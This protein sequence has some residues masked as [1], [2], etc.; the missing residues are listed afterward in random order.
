[1]TIYSQYRTI[2]IAVVWMGVALSVGA[3]AD[4]ATNCVRKDVRFDGLVRLEYARVSGAPDTK[5]YL[6]KSFPASCSLTNPESCESP[7]YLIGGDS[8]ALGKICGSWAFVQYIGRE[9]VTIGWVVAKKLA[10]APTASRGAGGKRYRFVLT[11]GQGVPVC[12]AYLQRLNQTEFHTP[13]Y[14]DR[15]ESDVVP[16]FAVLDRRYLDRAEYVATQTDI[17]D[18]VL[19]RPPHYDYVRHRNPDGSETLV[20]PHL[21]P[22]VADFSPA[23]WR[24]APPVD[25]ENSGHPDDL[26]IW[27]PDARN[28]PSMCGERNTRNNERIPGDHA[29]II[30]FPGRDQIDTDRTLALFGFSNLKK[31]VGG[32]SEFGQAY[33]VFKFLGTTYYDTFFLTPNGDFDGKRGGD[34]KLSDT[35][36]VFLYE[37]GAR[38]EMCEYYVPHLTEE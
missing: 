25:I 29:G 9:R 22:T 15:P 27:T 18:V 17:S 32:Q 3:R 6:H 24:Y 23:S 10:R 33:T 37:H 14:C 7:T 30:L 13:P 38:R 21:P 34:P 4:E 19:N 35:L 16:G 11:K 31:Y 5:L 28:Y 1:M 26:V 8:V 2:G 36:G 12:E 20:E